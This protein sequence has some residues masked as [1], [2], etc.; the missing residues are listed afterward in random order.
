RQGF[1]KGFPKGLAK[2]IA[3]KLLFVCVILWA[4][5][6]ILYRA[7]QFL[8]VHPHTEPWWSGGG[9][10]ASFAILAVHGLLLLACFI[11]LCRALKLPLLQ[12]PAEIKTAQNSPEC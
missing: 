10:L 6:A 2:W 8:F 12:V 1:L 5:H 7:E 4:C 11:L 9:S 3:I